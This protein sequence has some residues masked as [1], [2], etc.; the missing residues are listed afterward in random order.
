MI[1][2]VLPLAVP[3]AGP[4]EL[5]LEELDELPSSGYSISFEGKKIQGTPPPPCPP[6]EGEEELE[7]ELREEE[8]EEDERQQ[9]MYWYCLRMI[10]SPAVPCWISSPLTRPLT[11]S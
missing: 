3:V 4:D 1:W 6:P 9:E 8:L 2:R 7:D 11:G 10:G 5:L